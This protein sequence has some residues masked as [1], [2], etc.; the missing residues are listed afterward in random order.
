MALQLVDN[1]NNERRYLNS[2]DVLSS[3]QNMGYEEDY[4]LRSLNVH[5]KSKRGTNYDLSLLVEIIARYYLLFIIL[6]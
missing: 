5:R 6:F 4:I 3:L 2:N 1:N